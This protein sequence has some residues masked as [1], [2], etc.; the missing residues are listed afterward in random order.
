MKRHACDRVDDAFADSAPVRLVNAVEI[1]ATPE[2]IWAALE[3]ASAWPRWANVIRRVEWTSPEPRGVGTTRT[4]TMLG[5]LVGY[6]E[7]VAWEP[8]R[9]MT[10]RFNESQCVSVVGVRWSHVPSLRRDHARIP[11]PLIAT[12]VNPLPEDAVPV[13]DVP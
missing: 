2:Q 13:K 7:F 1:A 8:H 6:E 4:V 9:R 10:F 11:V 3:D 5:G 12:L